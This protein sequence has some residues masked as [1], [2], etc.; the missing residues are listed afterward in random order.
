[1][2]KPFTFVEPYQV[3]SADNPASASLGGFKLH[4]ILARRSLQK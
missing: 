2:A 4:L 1:M 3:V